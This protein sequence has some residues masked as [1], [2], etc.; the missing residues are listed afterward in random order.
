MG[1]AVGYKLAQA[2]LKEK[3]FLMSGHYLQL[4]DVFEFEYFKIWLVYAGYFYLS[5]SINSRL[6]RNRSENL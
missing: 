2:V 5:Q 1:N 6:S 3:W 4:K